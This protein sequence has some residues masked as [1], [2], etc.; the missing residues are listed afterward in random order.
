MYTVFSELLLVLMLQHPPQPLGYVVGTT[1]RDSEGQSL[2]YMYIYD[3]V[4]TEL[5]IA[6]VEL[7]D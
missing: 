7:L 2:M 1:N 6:I 5:Y 3:T 4:L